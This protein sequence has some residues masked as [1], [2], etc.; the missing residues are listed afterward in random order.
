[1][2]NGQFWSIYDREWSI[3]IKNGHLWSKNSQKWST[4]INKWLKMV[5]F[6][7]NVVENGRLRLKKD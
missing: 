4:L 3:L 2:G 5:Y 6:D 1:V 7:Q